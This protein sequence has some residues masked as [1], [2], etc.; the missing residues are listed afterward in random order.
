MLT[1]TRAAPTTLLL[2][3]CGGVW[4]CGDAR[5]LAS[6]SVVE[7]NTWAI[8]EGAAAAVAQEKSII[9]DTE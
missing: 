1:V 6:R 9:R 5:A 8:V 3:I 7:R 4:S 2:G